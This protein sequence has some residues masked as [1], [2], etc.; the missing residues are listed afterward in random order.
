MAV[1]VRK[2]VL[3]LLR[4]SRQAWRALMSSEVGSVPEQAMQ[5]HGSLGAR[6]IRA[7]L[8]PAR[9]ATANAPPFRSRL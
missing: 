7:F 3:S 8:G 2:P 5:H 4:S 1:P 6:A 9:L